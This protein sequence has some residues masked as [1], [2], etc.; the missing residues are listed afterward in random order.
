MGC[1]T[2]KEKIED[3]MMQIKLLRMEIQM[4]RENKVNQLSQMEGRKITYQHIPDYIDPQFAAEKKIYY[5]NGTDI[6]E[7]ISKGTNENNNKLKKTTKL[8]KRSKSKKK[9]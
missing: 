4:E 9:K 2:P 6:M 5:G 8:K 1:T 7:G 3:Q